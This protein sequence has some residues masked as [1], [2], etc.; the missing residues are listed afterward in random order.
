MLR[1][2]KSDVIPKL[3]KPDKAQYFQGYGNNGAFALTNANYS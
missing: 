3:N 1:N 2:N